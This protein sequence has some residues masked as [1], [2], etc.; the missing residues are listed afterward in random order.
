MF[1]SIF[2]FSS[3]LIIGISFWFSLGETVKLGGNT[4]L[5]MSILDSGQEIGPQPGY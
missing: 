4:D 2:I 5:E 3:G 1:L